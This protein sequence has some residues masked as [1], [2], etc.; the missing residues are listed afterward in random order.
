MPGG[1]IHIVERLLLQKR[2]DGC[3]GGRVITKVKIEY[4]DP[5]GTLVQYNGGAYLNT[6]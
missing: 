3:C 6:G 1:L 4:L 2:G 5:S